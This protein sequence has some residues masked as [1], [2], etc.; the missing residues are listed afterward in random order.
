VVQA[1][2]IKTPLLESEPLSRAFGAPVF[3]KMD[4]L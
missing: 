3:L 1:L 4:A 2:H